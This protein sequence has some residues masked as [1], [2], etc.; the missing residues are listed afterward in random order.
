MPPRSSHPPPATPLKA[1]VFLILVSL[2]EQDRHGYSVMQA[3]R[4]HSEGAIQLR[5][6]P[7]YRHLKRLLD[8]GFVEETPDRRACED[9][10]RRRCYYRLTDLGRR[11]VRTE[12]AR[13]A[14]LVALTHRL[15]LMDRV[16]T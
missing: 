5:T 9:D 6:G 10:R 2:A 8:L 12:S 11:V 14:K 13:L 3:V 7:L 1:E 15:G 4:Q 16:P